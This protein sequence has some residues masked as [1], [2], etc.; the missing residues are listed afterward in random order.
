LN[1]HKHI[2]LHGAI[3]ASKRDE[4][5]RTAWMSVNASEGEGWSLTVIEANSFGV[6]VLAFRRP[7]LRNSIRNGETGWL[8]GDDEELGQAV[9]RALRALADESDANAMGARARQW[10]SQFTWDEMATQ[11]LA[12]LNSEEARLAQYP[13]DRRTPTDLAMVARVPLHLLP[14]GPL[15]TFRST[16][17]SVISGDDLVVLLRNT[18]SEGALSALRRA[19]IPPE[20]LSGGDVQI[21]VATTVDLVSPAVVASAP[22]IPLDTQDRDALAG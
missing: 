9:G 5:L 1:L 2:V 16:D 10:A 7:G 12:L 19:G 6:P 18:D 22:P 13:N 15:P 3:N 4:L 11:V 21:S 14:S 17:K 8:I 20:V